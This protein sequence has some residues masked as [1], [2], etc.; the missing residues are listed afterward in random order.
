LV[1]E[2]C[3]ASCARARAS[4]SGGFASEVAS[5]YD[6]EMFA[7][8][9]T[10]FNLL[11]LATLINDEVLV[12]HGGLCRTGNA[13][14]DQLRAVDRQRPVPVSTADPRDLLFFDTM[15]ADPQVG[16]A[17]MRVWAHVPPT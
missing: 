7:L 5:K 13:T 15:W 11:P 17:H 16:Q 2:A 6:A 4:C 10:V 12:V 14:L 9:Q 3:G 1:A 8:F